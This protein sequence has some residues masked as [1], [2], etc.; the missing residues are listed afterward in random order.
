MTVTVETR[1]GVDRQKA[2]GIAALY[3]AL[4]L[5]GAI[6]Y[7]LVVVDYPNAVT[8]AD[9]VELILD[10]YPSMYAMY[11][12]T[13]VFFGLAVGVLALS[14]NDRLRAGAP[15]ATRIA[16]TIGMTWSFVLVASGLVFTYGMTTI[17]DLAA[18][19]PAEATNAWQAVEPVA[20]ALG[21]A[22]GELLGGL[23][24]LLASVAALQSGALSNG[25]G[26]LGVM[27]G[28][29]GLLSVVPPLQNATVAFGLLEIAWLAWLARSLLAV[30][31]T[32]DADRRQ[33][34]REA[35]DSRTTGAPR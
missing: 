7:F 24:V 5:L 6:P 9:K 30:K 31:G 35:L 10:H 16:T 27:I 18:T 12:A 11:L 33:V 15:L 2:G 25:L 17:H 19:D 3:L 28:L 26:R 21:G 14:L 20:L 1:D 34:T 23:W 29:I 22:G 8:A 13:Y 32:P 4:A